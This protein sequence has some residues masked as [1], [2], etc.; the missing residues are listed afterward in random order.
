MNIRVRFESVRFH[1]I[2]MQKIIVNI[3][4]VLDAG[5]LAN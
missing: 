5:D 4:D 2:F 1:V 3:I